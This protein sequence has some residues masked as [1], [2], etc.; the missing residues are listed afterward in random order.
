MLRLRTAATYYPAFR[1]S[2]WIDTAVS[3]EFHD[4]STGIQGHFVN[5]GRNISFGQNPFNS[6][7]Y[8]YVAK[9]IPLHGKPK[10]QF[11]HNYARPD[12]CQCRDGRSYAKQSSTPK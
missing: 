8:T 7:L 11:W 3:L 10:Q 9:L 5:F 4:Q 2:G 12:T 6:V 1:Q